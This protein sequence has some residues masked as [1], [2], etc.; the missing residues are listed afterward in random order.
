GGT[1]YVWSGVPL[2]W[3]ARA[4]MPTG[5]SGAAGGVIAGRLYVAGGYNGSYQ[6][7]THEY[8]PVGNAWTTKTAMTTARDQAGG[9]ALGGKLYVMGGF[10]GAYLASMA[11]YDPATNSWAAKAS[12]SV[13]RSAL[14]AVALG[15]RVYAIGGTD[16][17][18]RNNVEEYDPATNTWVSRSNILTARSGLAAAVL[19][20]KI[21]AIGGLNGAA[22]G[23][24]EEYAPE[25][26]QWTAKANLGTA[27]WRLAATAAN[28]NVFALGGHDGVVTYLPTVETY[29]PGT[30]AWTPAPTLL[31]RRYGLVAAALRDGVYAVGGFDSSSYLTV[32]Q[33]GIPGLAPGAAFTFTITGTSA[34]CVATPVSNTAW[35][36]GGHACGSAA[37]ASNN[38]FFTAAP[39]ALAFTVSK[40]VLPASPGPGDQIRYLLTVSNTGSALITALTL[41]DTV[42]SAIPRWTVSTDQPVSLSSP[43]VVDVPGTGTRFIWS[44][45]SVNLAAGASLTVTVY[46]TPASACAGVA[47]TATAWASA[48]SPCGASA[49]LASNPVS[50]TIPA[51]PGFG[52]TVVESLIPPVPVPGGPATYQIVVTNAGGSTIDSVRVT[53]TVSPVLV[54][55]SSD[56]PPTLL[57]APVTNV[58]GTGT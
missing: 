1:R 47:V 55:Q 58:A 4:A 2:A 21:L 23:T 20:G 45:A 39:V 42:P 44:G 35:V 38:V 28:R 46:G 56:R 9:A 24:V 10:N 37:V 34:A 32:N 50:F 31:N 36:A 11:A 43:A 3:S 27:R 29:D 33:R 16:G 57:A 40:A 15:G 18:P 52:I 5:R 22:L 41:V 12:M 8:D 17:S 30:G 14:A 49:A 25:T 26:D 48:S 54:G 53:D 7:A 6:T 19:G 13:A 51:A